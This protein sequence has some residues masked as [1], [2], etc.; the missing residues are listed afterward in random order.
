MHPGNGGGTRFAPAPQIEHKTRVA[1]RLTTKARRR[2]ILGSDMTF[3]DL[4]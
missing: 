1:G 3:N 4:Q 2:K